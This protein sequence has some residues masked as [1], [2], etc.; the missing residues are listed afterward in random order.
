MTTKD[1]KSFQDSP[2]SFQ[3][4]PLLEQSSQLNSRR[5]EQV[6]KKVKPQKSKIRL[7]RAPITAKKRKRRS[8]YTILQSDAI[9]A[10]V[11][12][13]FGTAEAKML[14]YISYQATKSKD[15]IHN[16][17]VTIP[18]KE[19]ALDNGLKFTSGNER[20]PKNKARKILYNLM[21]FEITFNDGEKG[22]RYKFPVSAMIPIPEYDT[23]KSGKIIVGLSP[24]YQ[25]MLTS[26]SF[27]T[28]VPRWLYQLDPQH[29]AAA[30]AIARYLFHNKRANA[31]KETHCYGDHVKI[32]TL[33]RHCKGAFSDPYTS[34]HFSQ[35]IYNPFMKA[36]GEDLAG[37]LDF[38]FLDPSG[39]PTM[40]T[41]PTTE[42][43][44]NSTLVVK[45][46]HDYPLGKIDNVVKRHKKAIANNKRKKTLKKQK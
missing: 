27:Y 29:Q 19:F 32:S 12:Q 33:L 11:S 18:V 14:D 34:Q 16:G 6:K 31:D 28:P 36:I 24:S 3:D 46:W 4:G 44:L 8:S 25:E 45:D 38:A 35:L 21:D 43:F 10:K 39:M 9:T 15:S 2:L 42:E 23:S 40:L 17:K 13:T 22:S 30:Y 7:S 41:D 20:Y 5:K 26:G 37:K 1:N